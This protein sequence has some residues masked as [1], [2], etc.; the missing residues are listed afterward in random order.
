M[1]VRKSLRSFSDEYN[2][3]IDNI[4]LPWTEKEFKLYQEMHSNFQFDIFDQQ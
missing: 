4:N 3:Y 2:L 1:A